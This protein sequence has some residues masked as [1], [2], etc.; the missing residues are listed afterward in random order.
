M[1]F[2][3]A[4]TLQPVKASYPC[5]KR[6]IDGYELLWKK[7]K[8]HGFTSVNLRRINQDHVEDFFGMV[9]SHGYRNIKPTCTQFTSVFKSLSITNLASVH[10]PGSNCLDDCTAFFMHWTKPDQQKKVTEAPRK[11]KISAPFPQ[12]FLEKE[13]YICSQK[14][15]IRRMKRTMKSIKCNACN[16]FIACNN[17]SF[18]RIFGEAKQVLLKLLPLVFNYQ[19]IR[20]V[21][22]NFFSKDLD[23]SCITCVEHTEKLKMNFLSS[24]S[25]DYIHSV[26]VYLNELMRGKILCCD[27]DPNSLALVCKKTFLKTIPK[28][29]MTRRN[30][31]QR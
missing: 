26:T 11:L 17:A 31:I 7:L 20:A 19:Q 29:V 4:T 16:N 13:T 24:I 22:C 8:S 18:G 10:S 14:S 2:V 28:K 25:L 9:R 5:L 3:N 21:T 27:R 6:N 30:V 1:R 15:V 12:L 23:F